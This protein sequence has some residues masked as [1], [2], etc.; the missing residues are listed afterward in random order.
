M[1]YC[2]SDLLSPVRPPSGRMRFVNWANDVTG[3]LRHT[4]TCIPSMQTP[5][6]CVL[7][8]NTAP[9]LLRFPLSTHLIPNMGATDFVR[10]FGWS[11]MHRMSSVSFVNFFNGHLVV[12]RWRCVSVHI[13]RSAIASLPSPH[14]GQQTTKEYQ[15]W[16][17]ESK[18]QP[19][20]KFHCARTRAR[21][22]A[23]R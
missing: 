20:T 19:E 5:I 6:S 3:T 21:R 16:D 17:S 13:V 10:R 4:V 23:R 14:V 1:P 9:P 2:S 8:A 15:E 22:R 11:F 18:A 12:G 7:P